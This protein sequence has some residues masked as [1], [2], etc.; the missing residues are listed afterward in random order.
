MALGATQWQTIWRQ[1]LPSAMSGILTGL[2]LAV[3]RAVGEAAPLLLIGAALRVSDDPEL[4]EGRFTALP[5][6]IFTFSGNAQHDIQQLASAGIVVM[7]VFVLMMNL[8]A[9]ILRDRYEKKW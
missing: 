2:I 1:V 3:S 5:V 7:L 4:F 9:V 6:N 8:S